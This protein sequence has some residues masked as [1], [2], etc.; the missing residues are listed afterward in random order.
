M[1][2]L[3]FLDDAMQRSCRRQRVGRLVAVG[4]IVVDSGAVRALDAAI[5][6]L[7]R[8]QYGFP[9]REAFKWS[10]GRDHWMRDNLV[11]KRRRE[12]LLDVLALAAKSGAVGQVTISDSTKGPR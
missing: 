3:L 6:S 1:L 7:C 12:F 4:G 2:K 10:P 8:T 5:E 9:E 11:D